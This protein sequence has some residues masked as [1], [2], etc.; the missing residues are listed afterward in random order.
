MTV[1]KMMTI[2]V[3]WNSS[4]P[5]FLQIL[6]HKLHLSGEFKFSIVFQYLSS[7]FC[8][9]KI[10]NI[11]LLIWLIDSW[12]G[13]VLFHPVN[14]NI[15][16]FQTQQNPL[17]HIDYN[18]CSVL[19]RYAVKYYCQLK[20]II[21]THGNSKTIFSHTWD[22]RYDSERLVQKNITTT[23]RYALSSRLPAPAACV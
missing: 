15:L 14:Y 23:V 8:A 13:A 11:L 20:C 1:R 10:M 21:P 4:V 16:R 22:V 17:L 6:S 3:S 7:G 9:L 18:T 12:L 19:V 5:N 2:L